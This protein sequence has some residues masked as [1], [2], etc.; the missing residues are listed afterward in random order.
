MKTYSCKIGEHTFEIPA[1]MMPHVIDY[2]EN[3]A[4]VGNF[5]TAIITNNLEGAVARA[6]GQNISNIPAY[7]CFFYNYAPADCYGS[8]NKMA[9]WYK[10]REAKGSIVYADLPCAWKGEG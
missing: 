10:T 7:V 3:G 5:L 1:Y 9:E 6:D 4:P 2:I 8:S